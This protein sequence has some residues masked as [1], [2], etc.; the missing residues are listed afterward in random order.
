MDELDLTEIENKLN[1]G[2]SG[3]QRIIF[4]YDSN[5][6]FEESVDDLQLPDVKI[7]HLTDRNAYRVKIQIEHD[8][9]DQ[10]FLLYAPFA[11]PSPENYHLEDIYCYSR[12]FHATRLSLIANEIGLPDRLMESLTSI[13]AFF[14]EG[15][16]S[17]KVATKRINAFIDRAKQVDFSGAGN[18]MIPL[19]AMCT[20]YN[21]KENKPDSLLYSIL[22]AENLES[23]EP[24][25]EFEKFGL[26]ENFWNIM[27]RVYGYSENGATL[28]QFA[29]AL[30]ITY[31]TRDFRDSIP[32]NWSKYIL[33]N[34]TNVTV[35]MDNMEHNDSYKDAYDE[36]SEYLSGELGVKNA[37]ESIDVERLIETDADRSVD[38]IILKWITDNET[39]ENATVSINDMSIPEICDIRLQKHF[40]ER[41]R[42][43]YEMLKAASEIIRIADYDP[44][45]SLED[46]IS[47]YDKNDYKIDTAYR[48]FIV[49]YDHV[50]DKTPYE[51]LQEKVENIYTNEFLNKIVLAW[52]DAYVSEDNKHI[53]PLQSDFY[54]NKI[55][56]KREKVAVII[57]DAFRYEVGKELTDRLNLDQ[58]LTAKIEPMMGTLP[59]YTVL[60]MAELL[61]HK[62]IELSEDCKKAYVDG[63]ECDTIGKR[64]K[65]LSSANTRS[66]AFSYKYD[67]SNS[68]TGI[69][70]EIT[71]G[72]E[73]IY[74]YH[75]KIDTTGEALM[76]ED[77][78][79]AGAECAMEDIYQLIRRLSKSC[80]IYNFIVTADHGFIYKRHRLNESDKIDSQASD[81]A[82]KDRRF[83]MDLRPI[84]ADGVFHL[85]VSRAP[86]EESK[87]RY[88][89]LAKGLSVFKAGGG[90]NFVH[91][92]SSPQEL[93]VPC[94][95]VN[96]KRGKIETTRV[97]VQIVNNIMKITNPVLNL[98]V[99]QM[100]PVTDMVKAAVYHIRFETDEGEV[101][102]NDYI[103]NAD[104]QEKDSRDR[105]STLRFDIQKREYSTDKKYYL[106]I[107]DDATGNEV[108]SREVRIDM[109]FVQDFGF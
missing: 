84:D 59:S 107:Y 89:M 68:T 92:G 7:L 42:Y 10:K 69:L 60:G 101:I 61:P 30:Y 19:I 62:T 47:R 20:L 25:Q 28:L 105:V 96:A 34:A 103:F 33:H 67:I 106:R 50:T 17:T 57:S 24:M 83:V 64:D 41:Y 43:E 40:G 95:T 75:N 23:D 45:D 4:W 15:K 87:K 44:A 46:I 63:Q 16:K 32:K 1:E 86:E 9:P 97:Q 5:A 82:V 90:M 71:S 102:S 93:L 85:E 49:A 79:F 94:I 78:V 104:S 54:R 91:G 37:L 11:K 80:N 36:M 108:Y 72:V 98:D 51:T 53:I 39:S 99:M 77:D 58:N 3:G 74:I 76:N 31:L 2:F 35:L 66:R 81:H 88:L 12:E 26:S 21:A 65:I 48:K 13:G 18:E 38:E 70:R 22:T 14:G 109:P 8:E 100:D 29:S 73:V 56:S 6:S 27:S 55:S 52:N